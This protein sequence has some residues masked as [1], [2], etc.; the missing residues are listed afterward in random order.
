[1]LSR[2]GIKVDSDAGTEYS[3][4]SPKKASFYVPRSPL[5]ML[6]N[7]SHIHPIVIFEETSDEFFAQAGLMGRARAVTN[8]AL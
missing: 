8:F 1:M 2:L 6:R 3:P 4:L 5:K 7:Q